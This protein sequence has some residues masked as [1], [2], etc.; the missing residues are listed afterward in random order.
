MKLIKKTILYYL[1]MSLPLLLIAGGI[2]YFLIQNEVH[3]GT[4]ESL[5]KEKQNAEKIIQSLKEPHNFFLCTDS[6]SKINVIS[7][8]NSGYTFSD[9]LIFDKDEKENINY[10]VLHSYYNSKSGNYLITIF[11]S[12]LESDELIEGLLT[13]LLIALGFLV[14]SFFIANLIFSK[15]LWKPFYKTLDTLNMYDVKQSIITV[16]EETNTDEFRILN[17]TL[18]TMTAKIFSDFKH[19]KEFT[20]NASHEIQTPLAIIKSKL[21]L[22]MQSENL[23]EEEMMQIQAID[24]SVN[25]LSSLNKALILLTKIENNQFTDFENINVSSVL[26][27]LILNYKEIAEEKNVTVNTQISNDILIQMN[28]DL[29]EIL[30][31]NLIS[32][33]IRHNYENGMISILLNDKFL[34]IDNTGNVM[35][36]KP[37]EMFERFKKNDASKDSIGLGLAIV[38]VIADIYFFKIHFS[39]ENEKFTFILNFN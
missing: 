27:K 9:T 7:Q 30:F 17:N 38:K 26:N 20:E 34:R 1:L 3:D 8:R 31:S 36:S 35:T 4:D 19:L 23:K 5:W 14:L 13:V 25:K 28:Q 32:N 39:N 22:L 2:S 33:S 24:D 6:L 12:T 21:D 18:T 15:K 29:C 10:R 11:R 37:S 16:F